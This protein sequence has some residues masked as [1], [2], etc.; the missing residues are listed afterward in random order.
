MPLQGGEEI[1][2]APVSFSICKM[3]ELAVSPQGRGVCEDHGSGWEGPSW[4][5]VIR[6]IQDFTSGIITSPHANRERRSGLGFQVT[7]V[8]NLSS[9]PYQLRVSGPL[10]VSDLC[11]LVCKVGTKAS[12]P[13]CPIM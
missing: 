7:L 11:R 8:S 12:W 1:Q 3:G 9:C 5:G 2:F 10:H 6:W 13:G 4:D